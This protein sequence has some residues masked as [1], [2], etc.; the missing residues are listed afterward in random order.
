MEYLKALDRLSDAL[1]TRALD[2]HI[3]QQFNDTYDE[4]TGLNNL[5]AELEWQ[6]YHSVQRLLRSMETLAN[7]QRLRKGI[8]RN[9][10]QYRRSNG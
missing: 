10:K 2:D 8:M 1:Q 3:I 5:V 7:S 9:I 6:N 4:A